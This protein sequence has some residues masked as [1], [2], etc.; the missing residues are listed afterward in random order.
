[1]AAEEEANTPAHSGPVQWKLSTMF[2]VTTIVAIA[3]AGFGHLGV[4]GAMGTLFASWMG[5]IGTTCLVDGMT[6]RSKPG[7][8]A[9]VV[10]GGLM[11][12]A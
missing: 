8:M 10:I 1:M 2:M 5:L 11:L 4:E 6:D 3:F 12:G 7:W 9:S